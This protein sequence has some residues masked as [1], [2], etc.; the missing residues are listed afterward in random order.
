[1]KK[2][3][4]ACAVILLAGISFLYSNTVEAS[5]W[6]TK[7]PDEVLKYFLFDTQS[8]PYLD[9]E[10]ENKTY[11]HEEDSDKVLSFNALYLYGQTDQ[12][13]SSTHKYDKGQFSVS[14]VSSDDGKKTSQVTM[15]AVASEGK[16]YFEFPQTSNKKLKKKVI[17]VPEGSFEFIGDS[18]DLLTL[19]RAATSEKLTAD[20]I[21][22]LQTHLSLIKKHNLLVR[23]T[24]QEVIS[25]FE[26][27]YKNAEVLVFGLNPS[28]VGAYALEFAKLM[29]SNKSQLA[30]N[31][32]MLTPTL[33]S[34]LQDD[35][36]AEI[37]T[38]QMFMVVL[39]DKATGNPTNLY[40][41]QTLPLKNGLFVTNESELRVAVRN[42]PV[43]LTLPKKFMTMDDFAEVADIDLTIPYAPTTRKD[44]DG[45]ALHSLLQQIETTKPTKQ[46]QINKLAL[47]LN[48]TKAKTEKADIAYAIGNL[49]EDLSDS[50][51]AS[52]YFDIAAKNYKKNGEDY[53]DA[54]VESAWSQ[55]DGKKV[56]ELYEASLKKNKDSIILE[57]GYGVF[58]LGLS[59]TSAPHANPSAA[60]QRNL[61]I[62]NI[63]E[64]DSFLD[65]L[66]ANYLLLGDTKNAELIKSRYSNFDNADTQYFVARAYHRMGNKVLADKF[67]KRALELG[68]EET[69]QSK[70]FF[71]LKFSSI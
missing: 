30:V 46:E 45:S 37:Y 15:N 26:K 53:F 70:A 62:V 24:D 13:K 6:T 71:D 65:P 49:Y 47:K 52:K 14:S 33:V 23:V 60:L 7:K 43:Q 17:E 56:V 66:Y 4:A 29:T 2:Q 1:M 16:V 61:K 20:E 68:F 12:A 8:I 67:R 54:L 55:K 22:Y 27:E 59:L 42:Q 58:L 51:N 32:E 35:E 69:V 48:R 40:R 9:V 41:S 21:A 18:L 64:L 10:V 3:I 44:A 31:D 38:S 50:T 11:V 34:A 25:G 36:F 19:F 57:S 39:I 63:F 28:T 5:V